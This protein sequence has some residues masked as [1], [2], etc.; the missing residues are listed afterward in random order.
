MMNEMNEV[1]Q[2]MENEIQNMAQKLKT[3]TDEVMVFLMN[4]RLNII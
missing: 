3:V 1:C 2:R 4:L